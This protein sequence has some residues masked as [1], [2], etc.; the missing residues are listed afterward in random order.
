MSSQFIFAITTPE[1]NEAA[2]ANEHSLVAFFF[3]IQATVLLH[4]HFP[5]SVIQ[6]GIAETR[7]VIKP[8]S[9]FGTDQSLSVAEN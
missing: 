5:S 6:T 7:R 9:C 3:T 4:H 1:G 8:Q 2:G